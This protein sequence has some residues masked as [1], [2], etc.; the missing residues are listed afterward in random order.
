MNVSN[1]QPTN[2]TREYNY[3]NRADIKPI[4]KEKTEISKEKQQAE[5]VNT[6][7]LYDIA[8]SLNSVDGHSISFQVNEDPP[9]IQV[10]DNEGEVIRD[11]P[12]EEIRK[13]KKAMDNITGIFV[14]VKA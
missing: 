2:N 1:I 10:K 8:Q 3:S 12:P 14:N 6:E 5:Q 13:L 9:F 4:E 7:E 11:I